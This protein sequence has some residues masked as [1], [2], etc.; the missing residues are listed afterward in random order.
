MMDSNI[1]INQSAVFRIPEAADFLWSGW[2]DASIIYDLRSGHT[3]VLNEFAR[4]IFAL[5]ED[6]QKSINDLTAEFEDITEKKLD[7]ALINKII[8]T[9]NE[10]DTMGLIEPV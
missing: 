9:L 7:Q 6:G 3:Q 1:I 10:F 2:D 8:A 4:E 5:F